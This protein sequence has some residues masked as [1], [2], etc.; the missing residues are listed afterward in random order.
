M[1]LDITAYEHAT[2]LD[3]HKSPDDWC[4][5][6]EDAGDD[7]QQAYVYTPFVASAAGLELLVSERDITFG[8]CY[9]LH[10][11]T[12]GFRAGSYSGYNRWRSQLIAAAN[13]IAVDSAATVPFTLLTN[14][15]DNEGW[16][17]PIAAAELADQFERHAAAVKRHF[18]EAS[19]SEYLIEKY[20]EW[21]AAFTLAAGTGVVRFH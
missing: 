4:T 9:R 17:G 5:H 19:Y 13:Q 15:A 1:G 2:L 21:A 12:L 7:H 14:F 11:T 16:I 8:R 20:D 10:G 3:D 6:A 18:G